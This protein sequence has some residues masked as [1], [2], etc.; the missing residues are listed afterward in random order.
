V[1]YAVEPACQSRF[2][3]KRRNAQKHGQNQKHTANFKPNIN[4]NIDK[5]Y[6]SQLQA[7]EGKYVDVFPLGIAN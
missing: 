4:V 6:G 1:V 2:R 7:K 3:H 5:F